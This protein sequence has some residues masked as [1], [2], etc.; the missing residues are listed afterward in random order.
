MTEHITQL[1]ERGQENNNGMWVLKEGM[2][3]AL[4]FQLE[5]KIINMCD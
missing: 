5:M 2:R 1:W 4:N 3:E